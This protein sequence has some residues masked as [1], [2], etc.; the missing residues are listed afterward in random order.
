MSNYEIMNSDELYH[1]GRKGMKWG[2]HIFGKVKA[3]T[4]RAGRKIADSIRDKRARKKAEKLRAKPL[5]KLTDEE[6]KERIKR[7]GIEKQAVDIMRQTSGADAKAVS[8]GKKILTS[9]ATDILAPTLVNVGKQWLTKALSKKLNLSDVDEA[10]K[11]LE[12]EAKKAGFERT[13]AEAKSA[14]KKANDGDPLADLAEKAKIAEYEKKIIDRDDAKAKFES[15]QNSSGNN[16]NSSDSDSKPNANPNNGSSSKKDK[17][18]KKV[19]GEVGKTEMDSLD[20]EE[21][22]KSL[23]FLKDDNWDFH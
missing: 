9:A 7:L 21:I 18:L 19:M 22:A 3:G 2:Q 15:K 8:A 14:V 16:A 6:L 17:K 10:M 23:G 12:T 4:T 20:Y 1:Y 13:I 11:K 5:S